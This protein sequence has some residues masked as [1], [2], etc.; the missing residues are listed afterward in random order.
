M[1]EW[2]E[3]KIGDIADVIGGG[4]PSTAV[5]EYWGGQIPWLT[6]RDLTGYK[7][8]FIEKGDRNITQIGLK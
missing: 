6:P 2:E 1:S 7:K 4:T 3:Y 8:I 5:S